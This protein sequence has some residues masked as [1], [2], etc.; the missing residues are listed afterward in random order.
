MVAQAERFTLL[1]DHALVNGR[2]SFTS[3]HMS[4]GQLVDDAPIAA[5]W[6]ATERPIVAEVKKHVREA[7]RA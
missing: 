3:R 2:S 6:A 1:L 7:E 4:S 5:D